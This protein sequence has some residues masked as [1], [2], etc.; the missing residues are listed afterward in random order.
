MKPVVDT[1]QY[2]V[3][4]AKNAVEGFEGNFVKPNTF[5]YLI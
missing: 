1:G 5:L 3:W 4:I 2:K